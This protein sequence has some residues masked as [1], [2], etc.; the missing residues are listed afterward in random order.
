MKR[1]F[2][3]ILI[4]CLLGVAQGKEDQLTGRDIMIKVDQRPDGDNQ[5]SVS[6]WMLVNKRGEQRVRK[7]RRY[8]KD[9]EGKGGFDTKLVVF[10]DYPPDV[11]G[12]GFLNWSYMDLE[13]DDDQWLYLPDLRKVRRIAGR[14]KEK[15]F[16]GSDFTFDDMGDRQVDEDFHNLLRTEEIAGRSYYIVESIPK[17]K[18][19]IYSKKLHWVDRETWVVPKIEFFDRKGRHLKTLEVEWQ[20]VDGIWTWKKAKME[21]FITGHKTLVEISEVKINTDIITDATF[22]ERTIR[23][24][25]R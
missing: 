15:A 11:K 24:G 9:Y 18:G 21:N 1:V 25:I 6:S 20:L 13:K 16:M 10:F 23:R 22:T 19:Y 12:T 17:K 14:D 7:T 3:P 4:I 8:W 2:L 5:A